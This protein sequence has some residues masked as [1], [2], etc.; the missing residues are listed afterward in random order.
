MTLQSVTIAKAPSYASENAGK[1]IAQVKF[2]STREESALLLDDGAAVELLA[3][4]GPFIAKRAAQA[5]NEAARLVQNAV[6]EATCKQLGP[7]EV[8]TVKPEPPF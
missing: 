5:A 7:I 1:W 2:S 3:M 6:E 4:V 8:G